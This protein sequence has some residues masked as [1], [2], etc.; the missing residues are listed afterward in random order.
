MVFVLVRRRQGEA[1][2]RAAGHGVT[3]ITGTDAANY[4]IATGG[5]TPGTLT[6]N[7]APLS[8]A[9]ADATSTYGT[10]AALG[11]VTLNGLVGGDVVNATTAVAQN[12]T[13]VTPAP[14]TPAGTYQET[15]TGIEREDDVFIVTTTDA[16]G[17][18]SPRPRPS[19]A[20]GS[21]GSGDITTFHLGHS[22][23][24]MRRAMGPPSVRP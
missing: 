8:W 16:R 11:A 6:I 2:D 20:A 10:L 24:P 13:P 1:E 17:R 18:G 15:V 5:N 4:V 3:G 21:T 7:K 23:L 12:G 14:R 22:L 9:V 19:R